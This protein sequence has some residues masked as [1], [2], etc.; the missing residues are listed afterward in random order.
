MTQPPGFHHPL[1]GS[2]LTV[3]KVPHT[4]GCVDIGHSQKKCP[5]LYR[6]G[7]PTHAG[8]IYLYDVSSHVTWGSVTSTLPVGISVL[9]SLG[10]EE[11]RCCHCCSVVALSLVGSDGPKSHPLLQISEENCWDLPKK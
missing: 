6:V 10:G 7:V 8:V 5:T 1:H 2:H 3:N 9:A 4:S 11:A